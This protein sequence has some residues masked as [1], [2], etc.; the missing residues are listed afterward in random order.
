MSYTDW[1][2]RTEAT[3]VAIIV[4]PHREV[5]LAKLLHV[6]IPVGVRCRPTP[7]FAPQAGLISLSAKRLTGPEVYV[8]PA[9]C[10]MW[11]LSAM[12]LRGPP[13]S[14][15]RGL[16]ASGGTETD[17]HVPSGTDDGFLMLNC[18]LVV[19]SHPLRYGGVFRA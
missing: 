13:I 9:P 11:F 3:T 8:V 10:G 6:V 12:S 16:M 18:L 17:G 14:T 5:A 15:L 4:I 19:P 2:Y 1:P 7:T